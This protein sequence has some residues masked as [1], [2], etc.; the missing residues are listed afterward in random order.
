[1]SRNRAALA[2]VLAIALCACSQEQ[3]RPLVQA[4]PVATAPVVAL[5]LEERIE[6][7]G[8]LVARL[9]TVIAAEV[10]GRVTELLRD[11]GDAVAQDDTLI[12][13][14]PERRVLELEAA[15]ARTAQAEASLEKER[16]A[17][18]RVRTLHGQKIASKSRLDEADTELKLAEARAAAERAQLGVAQRAVR[19]A[20]VAAPFGGLVARRFVNRGQFVQPGTALLEVVSLDPIDVT[21]HL[22]E[23]DSGRVSIGQKVRVSVAPYPERSFEATVDVVAPTIDRETRTLRVKATLTNPDGILRPG[24]FAR[25]DLG[26][27]TRRG[28]ALVPEEAVLQRSDGSVIFALVEGNRVERRLVEIGAFHEGR[29][30]IVAGAV[31][32]EIVVTRGQAGLIDGAVVRVPEDPLGQGARATPDLAGSAP[33]VR[34]AL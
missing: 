5:D 17:T 1:M 31:P 7:S 20:S 15:K 34:E 21:F 4:P 27:A 24:L 32:G 9:H 6:A 14:D 3:T 29:V 18:Q 16:R 22:P 19:D 13:I 10:S 2:A 12:E 8:E 26:V 11:E 28:V 33:P 23:I 30:E 25:A